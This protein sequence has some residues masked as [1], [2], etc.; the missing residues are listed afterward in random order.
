MPSQKRFEAMKLEVPFSIITIDSYE[1]AKQWYKIIVAALDILD[2]GECMTYELS[3]I[4]DEPTEIHRIQ[5]IEDN[6]FAYS[7][8]DADTTEL[9]MIAVLNML[10]KQ[11]P[12]I[13]M[14]GIS[15]NHQLVL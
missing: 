2:R 9:T 5:R 1:I 13:P 7:V 11:A 12:F 6:S 14:V 15:N 4:T 8:N 10:F 3:N